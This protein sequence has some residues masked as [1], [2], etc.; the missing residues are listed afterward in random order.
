M[1]VKVTLHGLL[2]DF[3]PRQARGKTTLNL[4]AGATVAD[5][6]QALKI[7]RVVHAVVNG[8]QVEITHMLKD[9]SELQLFRPPGGG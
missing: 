5:V 1:E 9:G 4:P 8:A 7:D 6:M 2:R 3:L